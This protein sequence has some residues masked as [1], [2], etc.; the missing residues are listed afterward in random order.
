MPR[1]DRRP[2]TACA[3][4]V[5]SV[6]AAPRCRWYHKRMILRT[7]LALAALVAAA[8]AQAQQYRWV[9]DKGR[10]QY[11]DRAPPATAKEVRKK[12]F[13]PGSTAQKPPAP[14]ELQVLQKNF[15]VSLYTSPNCK[16]PCA[17]A[18]DALNKRGVPF[19]EIQVWDPETNEALKKVSGGAEVPTLTVGRTVQKG[20]EAGAYDALL[21][22]AGYPREGILPVGQQGV[23]P[24]PEGYVP[25]SERPQEKPVAEP[26]KPEA[27]EPLGPYA[28]GRTPPAPR[29]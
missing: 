8:A 14:Y 23:P 16:E 5:T 12:D 26:V 28:P 17:L 6:T 19:G 11:T 4:G 18:R 1:A 2:D 7:G 27:P 24:P 29:K 15:P 25:V 10:V 20:F 3:D 22:S 21:D 9:D 13:R